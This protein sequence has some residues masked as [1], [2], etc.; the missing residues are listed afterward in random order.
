MEFYSKSNEDPL[1]WNVIHGPSLSWWLKPIRVSRMATIVVNS[2]QSA[3]DTPV[4]VSAA[5]RFEVSE[6][7]GL[8]FS[9]P[10]FLRRLYKQISEKAAVLKDEYNEAMKKSDESVKNKDSLE[11]KSEDWHIGLYVCFLFM[12]GC[13]IVLR[14]F[15]SSY[16][17]ILYRIVSCVSCTDKN[18]RTRRFYIWIFQFK[19]SPV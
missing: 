10:L 7:T 12:L 1:R 9:A 5:A 19:F 2:A 18:N 6:V 11:F 13:K 8:L 4:R 14:R 16:L 17:F 15:M 3:W